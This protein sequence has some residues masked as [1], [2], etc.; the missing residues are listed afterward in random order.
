[1][2]YGP[3]VSHLFKHLA[4]ILLPD[5]LIHCNKSDTGVFF[6]DGHRIEIASCYTYS[7]VEASAQLVRANGNALFGPSSWEEV[8]Y[9]LYQSITNTENVTSDHRLS[10][11]LHLSAKGA[12]LLSLM[13]R[14]EL[15]GI[16]LF[17]STSVKFD[18]DVLVSMPTVR[19]VLFRGVREALALIVQTA[20]KCLVR[21]SKWIFLGELDERVSN[22][23]MACARQAN[24]CLS[25]L[26]LTI[27]LVSFIL[28]ANE[29]VHM[30]DTIAASVVKDAFLIE[31]EKSFEE[32]FDYLYMEVSKKESFKKQVKL[33]F[34][35]VLNAADFAEPLAS[36][37]IEMLNLSQDVPA[38]V[39]L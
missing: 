7:L 2:K 23:G 39:L 14:T 33:H 25:E 18:P 6:Y 12:R 1:M 34:F 30:T 35:S 16:S 13:L 20:T 22:N 24:A 10:E 21:H 38:G 5:S 8:Q 32:S 4:Q 3:K 28:C 27:G 19:C 9:L 11:A 37:F 26:G 36:L 31:L 17:E 15:Q 29:G